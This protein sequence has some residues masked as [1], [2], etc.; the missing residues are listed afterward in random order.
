MR[1]LK[2][3]RLL[4]LRR[5]LEYM[6]DAVGREAFTMSLIFTFVIFFGESCACVEGPGDY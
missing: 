4:R 5:L 2:V 1:V 3:F 6:D